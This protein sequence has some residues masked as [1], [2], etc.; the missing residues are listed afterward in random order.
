MTGPGTGAHTYTWRRDD[1][2]EALGEL[3]VGFDVLARL[4]AVTLGPSQGVVLSEVGAGTSESLLDS[5]TIARRVTALPSRRQT[6]GAALVREMVRRVGGGYGDGG[7]TATVLAR[8][9]LRHATRVVAAGANP[10]LVRHGIQVG[11]AAACGALKDLAA[12]VERGPLAGDAG[13]GLVGLAVAATGDAELGA[14][15]GEMID[16]LGVEGAVQ[17]EEHEAIGLAYDYLDGARWRGRP[18]DAATLPGGS[19]ELTLVDPLVAVADLDLTQV[20]Q[21]RPLLE[22]ALA[23]PG[24]APLLVVARDITDGAQAMF[25]FNDIRGTLV[26][27]PVVVTTSKSYL[28][29]DLADLALLTGAEVLASE[30]GRPPEKFRPEY[31]GRARRALVQE[32]YVTVSGGRGDSSAV[33][34]RAARLRTRAWELDLTARRD[35][36]SA[37]ERLWLRQA[38]L[39]G[40]VGALRVGAATEQQIEARKTNAR[41]AVRLLGV[42]L[43][44]GVVPGGGVAYLDCIPA[45]EA[46]RAGCRHEDEAFGIDAVRAGLEAP[47]L[48]IVHN[49]G[50]RTPR[51]ALSKV[52]E[53]GPGHGL[54]VVANEFVDMRAAGICDVAAVMSVALEAAGETAGLLVSAEVVS[55]RD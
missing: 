32:G 51:V 50:R 3:R 42:A 37:R 21:V 16:I 38:R 29:D 25:G 45:V 36:R 20:E 24:R 54:D 22:A 6:A 43:R 14:V 33:A 34:D 2:G 44:D 9:I 30:L 26:S 35:E 19:T 10:V 5:A 52:R 48:Q 7:A 27:A 46:R 53:L 31:F 17:V 39:S 15:I 1:A 11:V 28:S 12:P 23:L 49:A 40:R 8:S 47:F 13:S 55:G 4:L 18:A 41:K